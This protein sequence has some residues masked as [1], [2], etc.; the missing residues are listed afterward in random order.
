MGEAH[1]GVLDFLHDAPVEEAMEEW[2]AQVLASPSDDLDSLPCLFHYDSYHSTPREG[3]QK[4]KN[5][6]MLSG[7]TEMK[8]QVDDINPVVAALPLES[9]ETTNKTERE[10]ALAASSSFLPPKKRSHRLAFLRC[11]D[12]LETLQTKR[13]MKH[14]KEKIKKPS[15][16]EALNTTIESTLV[17]GSSEIIK[18]SPCQ[19]QVVVRKCKFKCMH[20]GVTE[21]PQWRQGPMGRKTLCN[22]CGVRYRSGRLL[23]EYRPAASPTFVP[24]LHS[25]SLKKVVEMRE[26]AKLSKSPSDNLD[27]LPRLFHSVSHHSTPT[28]F[29]TIPV[30]GKKKGKNL[31]MLSGGMEMK[32][33]VDESNRGIAPLPLESKETTNKTEMEV[34]LAASSSSVAPLPENEGSG[35]CPLQSSTFLPPRRSHRLAFLRC[36]DFLETLQTTR[37]KKQDKE[38]IE[39]Q[40]EALNSIELP[41]L[42]RSKEIKD[43]PSQQ[44]VVVRKCK[45]K[46]C[47]VSETPLW[48][49]GPM[50]KKTLC[51]ACGV[52][53]R[54]GR[55]LPEYRP[56]ASPTFVPSLHSNS[57]KKVVEMREKAM[58]SKSPS[59]NFDNLP[60]L[61]HSDSPHGTPRTIPVEGKKKGKN[62]SMLSSGMEMKNQ[63]LINV[64]CSLSR[65]EEVHEN[66]P[67]LLAE[68]VGIV[69]E[70]TFDGVLDFL[71]DV[72]VEEAM[73]EWT[74]EVLASPSDDL[75]S[76]PCLFHSDSYHSTPTKSQRNKTEGEVALELAAS[77]SFLLPPKKRCSDFLETLQTNGTE[78]Q[79][80]EKIKKPSEALNSI[81]KAS[82]I[83]DSPSQQAVSVVVRKCKCMQCGV[84]QHSNPR[85]LTSIPVEGKCEFSKA[86][87]RELQLQA[88]IYEHIARGIPVSLHLVMPIWKSVASSFDSAQGSIYEHYPSFVGVIR[89]QG[90]D[91][92]KNMMDPEA[93]RCRRTD[94]RKWRCSKNVIPDHKYCEKHMHRARERSRK[95]QPVESSQITLPDSHTTLSKNSNKDS[96]SSPRPVVVKKCLATSFPHTLLEALFRK[97]EFSVLGA[98]DFEHNGGTNVGLA[99]LPLRVKRDNKQN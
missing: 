43:S 51:N 54:S 85:M 48:R 19:Q 47:G 39:E 46:H 72:P 95:K 99:P 90:F 8:N 75:D 77:S 28:M 96:S 7:S 50:G 80:K 21:T 27:N 68:A 37:T 55:L 93:G 25:N 92:K 1:D 13:T 16:S 64:G 91:Y 24:S 56:A 22:A 53:Y 76:L 58:L 12:F 36:S 30:E 35:P 82:E 59:D 9:K 23:P 98:F 83:K 34:V 5:S 42:S 49:D 44:P 81:K 57:H 17:S 33:Q 4:G 31:S 66:E 18:D 32:N 86:Q 10:V 97:E 38:K 74:A 78:K 14:D 79:D 2:T 26:K 94:G 67:Y 89:P 70:E 29:T 62:L 63:E 3:K 87:L 88:V 52:R 15:D 71:Y 41:L 20:C 45:C 69:S 65:E 6:S 84:S 11:S 73:E 40:S 60:C 61:F